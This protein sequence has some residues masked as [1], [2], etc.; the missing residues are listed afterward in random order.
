MRV[1][2][3]LPVSLSD[4]PL[5]QA[6]A[7]LIRDGDK[8]S[9]SLEAMQ[10]TDRI[11]A[12]TATSGLAAWRGLC[13]VREVLDDPGDSFCEWG[14]GSGLVTCVADMLGWKATGLEIEPRLVDAARGL[15]TAHGHDAAFHVASYK[16]VGFP[17]AVSADALDTGHGF[18]LFDFDVIYAYTWPAEVETVTEFVANNAA[19][20]TL[21][22][23]YRGGMDFKVFR[24]AS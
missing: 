20:G 3:S 2:E 5:T 22:L 18:G 6:A 19:P 21:F 9:R 4:T 1:L 10:G 14:S 12:F 17:D 7:R 16:P 8:R 13:A 24:V 11:P 23:R 15:A